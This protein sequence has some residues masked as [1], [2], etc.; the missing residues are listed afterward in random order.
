MVLEEDGEPLA[1]AVLDPARG[2]LF[3]AARGEG[4]HRDGVALRVRE[5]APLRE[6]VLSSFLRAD[7]LRGT[8][9]AASFGRLAEAAAV[10]RMGGAGL[11]RARLGGRGPHRRVGAAQRRSLGLAPGRLLVEEAGGRTAVIDGDPLTW[12]VAAAPGTFDELVAL[13]SAVV[14][15]AAQ[16][17]QHHRGEG[18]RAASRRWSVRRM[19]GLAALQAGRGRGTDVRR[20]GS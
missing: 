1:T 16:R 14:S 11:A 3:S 2:E 12:F 10:L 6:A 20:L 5:G 15:G 4:A 13:V 17:L 9:P 8:A 19:S 18:A 7:K